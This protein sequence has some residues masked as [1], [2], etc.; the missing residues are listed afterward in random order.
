[1]LCLYCFSNLIQE[2]NE[3]SRK[4]E[5]SRGIG[6]VGGNQQM[7]EPTV[8]EIQKP[9][10]YPDRQMETCCSTQKRRVEK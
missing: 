9:V 4:N 3:S 8:E 7:I 10:E 1:M 5:W 6:I 2:K